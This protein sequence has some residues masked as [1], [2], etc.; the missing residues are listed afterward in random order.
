MRAYQHF[1]T[2]TQQGMDE[3]LRLSLRAIET[4]PDYS[5]PY[6]VALGC[7]SLRKGAGW[8]ADP[9]QEAT[10]TR[11]LADK[12]VLVGREDSFALSAA[13]FAVALVLGELEAGLAL[14]ERALALNPNAALV[15]TH[16]G[17]VRN[18]LGE[19]E[20]A[21]ED[22][23]RAMQLSPVDALMFAMQSAMA[24]AHYMAGRDE[25]ALGWAQQA[26][27]R[28]P[29]M[30]PAIRIAA[31]SAALLGRGEEAGKYLD[32]LGQLDPGQRISNL[33]ERVTLRRAE[34]RARLADG[35]RRAGLAE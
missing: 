30:T 19:H 32:L 9:E 8:T 13:G 7:Y 15:R 16:A 23:R 3:A 27:Q 25:E 18:W 12:A 21:I 20:R 34:D 17:Y 26:L 2:F 22:L 1:H 31:A 35:L 6:A 10:E 28:N 11:R 4:D 24:T 29:F 5:M 33:G 14:I